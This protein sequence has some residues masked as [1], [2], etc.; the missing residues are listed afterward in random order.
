M[1]EDET[2]DENEEIVDNPIV[3]NPTDDEGEVVIDEREIRIRNVL[4]RKGK[5]N[6]RLQIYY[7]ELEYLLEAQKAFAS[8]ASSYQINGKVITRYGMS[9]ISD[10]IDK[11]LT[12]IEQLE[13]IV[14]GNG[15]K[16]MKSVVIRDI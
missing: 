12:R 10:R 7:N 2:L 3:D 14:D 16:K 6:R 15:R 11:L 1:N 5:A 4:G 13:E 8:G 9:T